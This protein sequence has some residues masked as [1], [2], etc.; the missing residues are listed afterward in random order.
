M[1][2]FLHLFAFSP[3]HL[4]SSLDSNL[5]ILFSGDFVI[6]RLCHLMTRV[7]QGLGADPVHKIIADL[8]H[9]SALGPESEGNS[10][11][12][13]E[14]SRDRESEKYMNFDKSIDESWKYHEWPAQ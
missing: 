14:R 12:I 6:A 1:A 11:P 10:V 13:P 3:F 4:S 7:C 5:I 2:P 9:G 8:D